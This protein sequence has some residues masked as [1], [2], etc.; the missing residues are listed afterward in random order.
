MTG[1]LALD[2]E[3]RIL[4]LDGQAIADM[5]AYM[6]PAGYYLGEEYYR[7][8]GLPAVMNE[9]MKAGRIHKDALTINGKTMGENCRGKEIELPDVIRTVDEPLVKDAGFI[10]LRGKTG[11]ADMRIR[12]RN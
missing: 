6:Q 9:L 12:Q 2:V 8:G 4:A 1:R 7:A 10:V 11:V 3:G 5:G